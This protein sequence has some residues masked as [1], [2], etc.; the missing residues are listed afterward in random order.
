MPPKWGSISEISRPYNSLCGKSSTGQPYTACLPLAHEFLGDAQRDPQCPCEA[1]NRI[2]ERYQHCKIDGPLSPLRCSRLR[3]PGRTFICPTTVP[4]GESSQSSI[5]E[6]S[7][8]PQKTTCQDDK[9]V[10]D[11][12]DKDVKIIGGRPIEW[13]SSQETNPYATAISRR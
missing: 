8:T 10:E 5:S 7:R 12:P 3:L 13:S 4:A 9:L 2:Q 1:R 6:C 11:W